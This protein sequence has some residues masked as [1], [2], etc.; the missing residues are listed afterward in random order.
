MVGTPQRGREVARERYVEVPQ[1]GHQAL[2]ELVLGGL[3]VANGGLVAVVEEMPGGHQ[4]VAAVVAGAA[5]D[6][7]VCAVAGRVDFVH[8][9][10]DGEAG[11]LHQLI[12]REGARAHE[13]FVQGGGVGGAEG[14]EGHSEHGLGRRAF[15][16][17]SQSVASILAWFCGT[18]RLL[19]VDVV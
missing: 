19:H 1:L 13:V 6:Q 3:R 5:H 10:R 16:M 15:W 4:A 18:S 12:E 11:E 8:G 7:H 17:V 2:V 14:F 9:L